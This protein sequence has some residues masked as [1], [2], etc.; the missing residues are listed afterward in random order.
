MLLGFAITP[1]IVNH[2]DTGAEIGSDLLRLN[3]LYCGLSTFQLILVFSGKI[4]G[5]N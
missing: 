1:W 4:I 3:Y 5:F 2:Y